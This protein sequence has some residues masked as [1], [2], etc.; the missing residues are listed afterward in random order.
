MILYHYDRLGTLEPGQRL[1]LSRDY[2]MLGERAEGVPGAL[3]WLFPEGMSRH[4]FLYMDVFSTGYVAGTESAESLRRQLAEMP[5]YQIEWNLELVRRIWFP[6]LPS[7]CQ[8]LF[9]LQGTEDFFRWPELRSS[10]GRLFE[11]CV[12]DGG[13][14]AVLDSQMLRGGF[15]THDDGVITGSAPLDWLCSK[16]YWSGEKSWDPRLEVVVELPVTMG[17]VLE[18][19]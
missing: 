5:S 9:C 2:S 17:R 1:E 19:V 14:H 6:D 18:V 11:V 3:S 16:R 8:S 13:K 10:Q 12:P 15:V 7:R 4:G